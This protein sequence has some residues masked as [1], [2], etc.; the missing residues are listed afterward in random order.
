MTA[1]FIVEIFTE[2]YMF[3]MSK[4]AIL[5]L[6]LT[7]ESFSSS[8]FRC[9]AWGMVNL[10]YIM[11]LESKSLVNARY[12][13]FEKHEVKFVAGTTSLVGKSPFWFFFL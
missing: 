4:L 11:L 5:F 6:F 7:I 12:P 3:S 2:G 1:F 10:L 8:S 13:V 9:L